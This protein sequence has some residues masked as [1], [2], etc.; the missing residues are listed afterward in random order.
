MGREGPGEGCLGAL[1]PG[2]DGQQ[3]VLGKWC[4][5]QEGDGRHGRYRRE[6]QMTPLL[7]CHSEWKLSKSGDCVTTGCHSDTTNY[8]TTT[9]LINM[10]TPA[11]QPHFDSQ[12][13]TPFPE[14]IWPVNRHTFLAYPSTSGLDIQKNL[15]PFHAAEHHDSRTARLCGPAKVNGVVQSADT[16]VGPRAFEIVWTPQVML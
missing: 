14:A 13:A 10:I 11:S 9:W 1:V 16:P 12:M 15:Q 5:C 8:T 4:V 2:A 3:G 7:P 6:W